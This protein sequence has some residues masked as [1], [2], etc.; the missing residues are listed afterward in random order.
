MKEGYIQLK[1][2]ELDYKL[3]QQ[4]QLAEQLNQELDIFKKA[5]GQ[6]KELLKKLKHLDSFKDD[7]LKEIV[8]E[9]QRLIQSSIA[10]T[11]E[12]NARDISRKVEKPIKILK[13]R[14]DHLY[15][16]IPDFQKIEE[17]FIK[18]SKQASVN[19]HLYDLLIEEL[20]QERVLSKERSEILQKRANIRAEQ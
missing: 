14:L 1:I 15:D 6:Q 18:M 12:Q 8:K 17:S 13:K 2:R 11:I 16:R 4:M 10:D 5:I 3:K 7:F 9:N 20:V 19:N